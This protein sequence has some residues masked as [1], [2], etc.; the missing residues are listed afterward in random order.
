MN[1]LFG[2]H[3]FSYPRLLFVVQCVVYLTGF[4]LGS[5][6]LSDIYLLIIFILHGNGSSLLGI[7]NPHDMRPVITDS[8]Y[9]QLIPDGVHH[10]VCQ[11]SKKE[12][13]HRVLITLMKDRSYFKITFQS[14]KRGLYFADSVVCVPKSNFINVLN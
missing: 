3:G 6:A 13:R 4:G 9:F 5:A 12:M 14:P 8:L 11:H 10:L 7:H 2:L 1:L